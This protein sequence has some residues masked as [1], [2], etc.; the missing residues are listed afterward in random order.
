MATEKQL[1]YWKSMK[2]KTAWNKGLKRWWD[3]PTEFKKGE[4]PSPQTEIH[5]GQRLSPKTEFKRKS[6][7]LTYQ[8][9][10]SWVRRK[11]GNANKCEQCGDIYDI[12]WANKSYEYL[13]DISD[14]MQLCNKCHM[15]YD[16]KN[17]WGAATIKY[18]GKL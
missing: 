6:I 14:W 4:H 17:G 10:H 5:K 1:K 8:G 7:D 9:I 18:G 11:F 15:R 2:G 3:S 13:E 16:R 12:N